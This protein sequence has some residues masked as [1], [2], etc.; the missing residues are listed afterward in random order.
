MLILSKKKQQQNQPCLQISMTFFPHVRWLKV[1]FGT[2]SATSA[3]GKKVGQT[4]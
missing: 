1:D 4:C 3:L 2:P